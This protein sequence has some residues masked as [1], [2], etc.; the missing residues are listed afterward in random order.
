M[1]LDMGI[2]EAW[3]QHCVINGVRRYDAAN[4]FVRA[5]RP[6]KVLYLHQAYALS[7]DEN[8]VHVY[9]R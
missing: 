4:M 1:L 2:I 7:C 9:E 6:R 5:R 8:D 3:K